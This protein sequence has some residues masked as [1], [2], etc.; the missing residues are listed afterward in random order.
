MT[1]SLAAMSSGS[2][3]GA[4]AAVRIVAQLDHALVDESLSRR[5]AARLVAE[6]GGPLVTFVREF[7]R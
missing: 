6:D 4:P 2:R 1:Y 3:A 7:E 5:M